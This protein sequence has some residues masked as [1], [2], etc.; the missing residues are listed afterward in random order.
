[1][2]IYILYILYI[3][4]Y[5]YS[6]DIL[7]SIFT[8]PASLLGARQIESLHH[9]VKMLWPGAHTPEILVAVSL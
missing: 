7:L 3:Y 4:I 8:D 6:Y 9:L 2:Y 5:V 1:M